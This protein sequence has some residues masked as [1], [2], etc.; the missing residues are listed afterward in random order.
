ML[1]ITGCCLLVGDLERSVAFYTEQVGFVLAR[2]ALGFAQYRPQ[3]VH[4][5]NWE[6]TNFCEE[7]GLPLSGP[8]VLHKAMGG[9]IVASEAD[10]DRAYELLRS[11]GVRFPKSPQLYPWNA[12]AA[13]FSDP[14]GNI[15]EL[16][17]WPPSGHPTPDLPL[18]PNVRFEPTVGPRPRST[19]TAANARELAPTVTAPSFLGAVPVSAICLLCHDV[20][21]LLPFYTEQMGLQV[22]RQDSG[23]FVQFWSRYGI[24]LCL[25]GI[26]HVADHIGF[27]PWP[28]GDTTSKIACTVRAESREQ[29]D[30]L[31]RDLTEH[32]VRVPH[33]PRVHP[34]NV[35]A[36]YFTDPDGNCW[37]I[38]HWLE[39][40]PKR[41]VYRM[42]DAAT[43]ERILRVGDTNVP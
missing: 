39:G 3:G 36:F 30:E 18:R 13:Y 33:A 8:R 2:K 17:S 24:N 34:W 26:D 12:Y 22:R 35:Y 1:P 28:R 41:D 20:D 14:D 16:Y 7:T 15:W 6:F 23:S 19:V 11:R 4:I 31:H 25:W 9:L 40:G 21:E 32:G 42:T 43:M 37:E 27:A 29:V 5:S 10:V 38:Y